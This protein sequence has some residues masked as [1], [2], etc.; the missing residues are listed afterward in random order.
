MAM[1]FAL[2]GALSTLGL[3]AGGF[4]KDDLK[5]AFRREALRVHPDKEGGSDEAFRRF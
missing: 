3:R 1:D 5:A 4:D 2:G